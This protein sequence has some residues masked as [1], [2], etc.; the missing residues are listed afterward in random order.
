MAADEPTAPASSTTTGIPEPQR[1]EQTGSV[2][3]VDPDKLAVSLELGGPGSRQWTQPERDLLDEWAARV[4]A[5][6]HAHYHLM[7]GL[8]RRNL[9]LGIPVVVLSAIVGTALFATVASDSTA[10]A[11]VALRLAAGTISVLAAVLAGVQTF[12]KF[13]E[14]AEQ[15]G[16]AADW[17][18]AVRRD[19]D[20]IRATPEGERGD[21]KKVLSDL[22][23]EINKIA[24]NA[25]GIGEKTW[26]EYA[27][28][29]GVKEPA[30]A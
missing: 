23:K 21:P 26:H 13:S 17:L 24:Q 4:T 7:T 10:R 28:R 16:L 6:Q 2:P 11:P 30:E 15:H 8:R 19:I 3:I 27:V 1:S 14:R 20:L 9:A 25:P 29:Y 12:L 22:R 18:A 5:A